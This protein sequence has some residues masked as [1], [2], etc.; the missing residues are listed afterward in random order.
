[1]PYLTPD[2]IPEGDDCRPLSIPAS[3]EWLA[4]FGGALTE[5]TKTYNW[6]LW[7]AVSVEDTV[8]KMQEIID[9]WYTT[10]CEDC[11]LPIGTPVFRL[12]PD[13]GEIQ[14]LVDGEW[15]EPT[16]DY[17]LPPTPA[18]EESTPVERRCFAAANA[19][20][21]L[22]ILYE[23]L[24]DDFALG[25]TQLEAQVSFAA[26]V[27]GAIGAA[28]GLI[29]APLLTLAGVMFGIVYITTEFLT[30]DLWDETFE[31]KLKCFFYECA[32]DTDDVIHFDLN[33]VFGKIAASTTID[34]TAD[35]LRLLLQI[36]TIMNM[37]GSQAIDAA[38]ATTAIETADCEECEQAWCYTWDFTETDGSGDGWYIP[39]GSGGVF[40]E[41]QSGVGY[42]GTLSLGTNNNIYIENDTFIADLN[43]FTITYIKAG[44]SGGNDRN[45]M[46]IYDAGGII[47]A[48]PVNALSFDPQDKSTLGDFQ[49]VTIL[50]ANLNAG[51][52]TVH[53]PIIIGVTLRGNGT[54]PFGDDN[55]SPIT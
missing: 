46:E 55:C 25:L 36:G 33:C 22:K 42:V 38:G 30:A 14:Q 8:A 49:D 15:V 21:A 1:M 34:W 6:Q 4:F 35:E 37:L 32:S 27:T 53:D 19:A 31:E 29:T 44:G 47:S 41:Y 51:T 28:F 45:L 52:D 13:T 24:A 18:R 20:N 3:S 9:A 2:S 26:A 48:N 16:G 23:Q 10:P 54:N 5:L 17:A 43:E 40:G 50:V 11:E 12:D 39:T 7:G